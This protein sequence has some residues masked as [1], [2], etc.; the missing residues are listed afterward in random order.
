MNDDN[1][2][3]YMLNFTQTAS[4]YRACIAKHTLLTRLT[5][6]VKTLTNRMQCTINATLATNYNCE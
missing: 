3:A 2:V 5:N 4:F 1:A 6:E